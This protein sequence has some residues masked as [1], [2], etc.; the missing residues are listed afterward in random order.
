[1]NIKSLLL[2]ATIG[3]VLTPMISS[4]QINNGNF[5]DWS[6]SSPVDWSTIDSGIM[7]DR[8]TSPTVDGQYAAKVTVVTASQASTDFRQDVQVEANKNYQ[9]QVSV[10][11]TEGNVAVRLFVDGYRNYSDNSLL[12]QWQQ[13]SYA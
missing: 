9:F 7:L 11:H 1:M 13:L 3:L 6:N 10:Y 5:E 2:A 4:A 8:V 12:N